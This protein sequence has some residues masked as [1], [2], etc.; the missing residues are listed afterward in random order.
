MLTVLAAL[1]LLSLLTSATGRLAPDEL[2]YAE[3]RRTGSPPNT[4]PE[5]P[6]VIFE[7]QQLR[8]K[9]NPRVMS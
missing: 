9:L 5:R 1:S 8:L 7:P 6:P 3:P 2:C 4:Q